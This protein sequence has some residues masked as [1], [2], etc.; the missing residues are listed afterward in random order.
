MFCIYIAVILR[1]FSLIV[2]WMN[3]IA[4][5]KHVILLMIDLYSKLGYC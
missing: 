3:Y 1:H 5:L 4:V 2:G